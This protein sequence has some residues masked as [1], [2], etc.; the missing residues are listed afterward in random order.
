MVLLLGMALGAALT[1]SLLALSRLVRHPRRLLAP[2]DEATRAAL[3]HVAAMLPDLR[4]G[5]TVRSAQRAVAHVRALAQAPT[6]VLLDREQ[7]LARAGSG[8][9]DPGD[10]LPPVVFQASAERVHVEPLVTLG[11]VTQP[12][13][14]VVVALR[15]GEEHVGWLLALFPPGRVRAEDARVV[16]ETAALVSAQVG[17]SVLAEQEARASTAELRALRAQISPHFVYNAMAAIAAL[18][19]TAPDEARELLTEFADFTRYA[20]REQRSYVPLADELHYVQK[21][22]RLEQARF[23]DRLEVRVAVAPEILG[24][25]VPVLSLQPLVENAIRHGVEG[26]AAEGPAHVEIVGVDLDR[27]VELRVTDDGPGVD[28][29]VARSALAGARGGIGLRNVDARLRASFGESYGLRVTGRPEQGTV[30]RMRVPK[31]RAEV[32][33]QMAHEVA[34]AEVAP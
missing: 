28:P 16:A 19:H 29:A 15:V 10:P 25:A 2:G 26:R 33:A 22:L 23:G 9:L 31:F 34:P 4:R 6:V 21:Y 11:D 3:H 32:R 30:V 24:A 27:D 14:A 17:L 20:F 5:L 7:V 12:R 18:I 8:P 13:A 1:A